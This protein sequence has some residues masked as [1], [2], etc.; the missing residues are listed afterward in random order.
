MIDFVKIIQADDL[1]TFKL[2]FDIENWRGS[3][4]QIEN[5]A[6]VTKYTPKASYN[7]CDCF[8][9]ALHCDA[10]KIFNYL[11]PLV[12]TDKHG[13]NYGWPL[14]SMAI[15]K[16]RYDYANQIINHDSFDLY[17]VYNT[18]CFLHIDSRDN[19]PEHI[20]FLFNYLD[21]FSKWIFKDRHFAHTFSH[22]ICYNEDTYHRFN[23]VYQEKLNN[24]EAC[25]LDM[26]NEQL[27]ILGKEILYYHFKP[28]MLDKL[29]S[30][31]L[32]QLMESVMDDNIVFMPLFEGEHFKEGLSYLAKNPDLLQQYINRNAVI[33]HYLPLEGLQALIKYGIDLFF[34]NEE[35]KS[36]IDYLLDDSNLEDATT[37]YFINHYT[38][39]VYDRLE[40][41][42]RDN[43]IYK[44]CQQKLL[45]E[46]ITEQK[47]K[48][49]KFKI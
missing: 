35:N 9:Y 13:D 2:H 20:N 39:K 24:K 23:Q 30:K 37:Q 17:P 44:Y 22:L 7:D 6:G 18:N 47:E 3:I 36:P 8:K 49:L 38:Q 40:Q 21:K 29:N 41:R 32:R 33:A 26:F 1:D 12:D 5:Y 14:L 34:V 15:K 19:I 16:N 43:N 11:L 31:Q 28:F 42:G 45:S 48:V 10:D 4:T 46:Q 25:V 27:D